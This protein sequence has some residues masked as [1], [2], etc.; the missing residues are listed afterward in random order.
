MRVLQV[1]FLSAF[2]LEL[3]AT[4]STAII[5]VEVGLRL[6]Y[7]QMAFREALFLL[8]LAPEFYLPLRL[9]GMRFHAGMSG[10][11]AARRIFEV[12]DTPAPDRSAAAA[13]LADE[14]PPSREP[15]RDGRELQPSSSGTC[16][17]PIPGA[18]SPPFNTSI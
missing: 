1:S 17:T 16:P 8:V 10:T 6:L 5:A 2:A 13:E 7:G 14:G 4:I 18:R 9:L 11:A 15:G 3:L 12:L